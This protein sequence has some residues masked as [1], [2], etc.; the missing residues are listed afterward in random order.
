[1]VAIAGS[2]AA[3]SGCGFTGMWLIVDRLVFV[4]ADDGSGQQESDQ[5]ETDE[6]EEGDHEDRHGILL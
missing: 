6:G 1:V 2:F 4:F 5:A 3:A